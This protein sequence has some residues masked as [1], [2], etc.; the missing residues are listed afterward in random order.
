[1]PLCKGNV[2]E[3]YEKNNIFSVKMDDD[4]RYGFYKTNMNHVKGKY[5]SFQWTQKGD[6]RNANDKTIE[7][8]S[9]AVGVSSS[10]NSNTAAFVSRPSAGG[11]SD[12][13]T[14]IQHQASRNAAIAFVGMC[15][16]AGVVPLPTKVGDK[17]DAVAGLVDVFTAR[18]FTSTDETVAAGGMDADIVK[19]VE[20][21]D[22]E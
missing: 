9:D 1:M 16:Q 6:F 21:E 5:I 15:L 4:Q 20:Q 11:R 13:Q 3:V 8:I 18:Y 17:L 10:S 14:A 22:F 12:T 19:A 7:V 2:V